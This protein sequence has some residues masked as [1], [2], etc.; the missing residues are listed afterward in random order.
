MRMM[1]QLW[2]MISVLIVATLLAPAAFAEP[3]LRLPDYVTDQAGALNSQQRSEVN[4]AVQQLY[5]KRGTRLWVVYVDSFSGANPRDWA[6]STWRKSFLGNHDAILAVAIQDRAYAL[7][8]PEAATGDVDVDRLRQEVVEAKLHDGDWAGAAVAAADGLRGASSAPFNWVG[9]VI[10]LAVIGVAFAGLIWWA[11]RRR[12]QRRQADLNAAQQADATDPAV[13][14]KMSPETL[15][16]LSKSILVEVDNAVR[17]SDN[18]LALAVGEFGERDTAPFTTAVQN[19]KAAMAQ[20]FSVRQRLDD[21]VPETPQQRRE[22][23]TQVVLAAARADRELEDRRT[24][25]HQLR[26]LVINAPT[27]LEALTQ[28]MVALTARIEPAQQTLNG[29]HGQFTESALASVAGNVD[30][31]RERLTFAD[32]NITAARGLVSKPADSQAAL[33]NAIRAAES[34][35]GQ[36]QRLLD[37]VDSAATDIAHAISALPAAITDIQNGI[38]AAEAVPPGTHYP[39]LTAARTAAVQAVSNAQAS[40]TADPLSAFTQLTAA[41]SQLDKLLATISEETAAMNRLRQS[42]GQALLAAQSRVRGVSDFIDTRRGSVGSEARTRLAEAQR[43]LEAAQAAQATDLPAAIE[44]ANAAD[45]LAAQAQNLADND[46][47]AA[48]QA[49]AG[50]GTSTAGDIGGIIIGGILS[51][52]IRGG[53]S[54]GGSH[55]GG[56]SST[57]FGGS[58]GGFS[59]GGGRF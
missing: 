19:A 18:E 43:R 11:R 53:G 4:G 26:D 20:A 15:E 31:A 7:L 45:A 25:F 37:S 14:A 57:S 59:G 10:A 56:W 46:V 30:G 49:Y 17:T 22:L 44:Q 47:R 32:Q 51:G 3:P 54:G 1:R 27:R 55:G 2:L 24:A 6:E 5:D 16:D 50:T 39:E 38:K 52:M 21:A 29:L 35:L 42:F 8:A 33:V 58:G 41:D 36:A 13:L 12:R 9:L 40:G 48:R 28:Q 34:A 23:L